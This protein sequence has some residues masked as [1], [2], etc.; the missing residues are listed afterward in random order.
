MHLLDQALELC[1]QGNAEDAE[2]ILRSY[3]DQNDARV[4]FNLGWHEIRRG[5]LKTGLQMMDAGRFINCFGS[6]RIPGVIWRDEDLTNKTLLLRLE[7]GLGDQIINFRFAEDFKR[8]GARVVI[9]CSPE[10]KSLFNNHGFVCISEDGIKNLHYDYWV[11]SMSAAHVLN[12]EHN[13]LCGK[14]YLKAQ[15]KNLY[16]KPGTL[17][18]GIR[19]AGN[20]RFEHEQHRKFDPTQLFDL[21]K[22]PNITMYSLQR[23]K[24]LIDGLPFADLKDQMHDWDA[25]A[26]I[27]S[28]L[29]LVISSCTSVAHCAAALGIETWVIV[30]VLP[31]YLWAVPGNKSAWYDSVKI[32]R[33]EKY[34][35]WDRPLKNIRHE[36]ENK[37]N[38]ACAA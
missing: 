25:T 31:Y 26:S 8:M 22:L 20:P 7:G 24:D 36:L 6:P 5:N 13:T 27:L 21:Y 3:P 32:F 28:G 33:Q 30:P 2:K 14:P 15:K 16:G 18:V 12:Y 35:D 34:G 9:S 19:W 37:C 4:I 29:D 17:K 1:I 23:D 11:P 38:L 10:I